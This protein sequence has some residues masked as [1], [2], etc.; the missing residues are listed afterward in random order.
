MTAKT[1]RIIR[2][3]IGDS[4]A[5]AISGWSAEVFAAHRQYGTPALFSRYPRRCC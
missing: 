5:V 3:S 2:S 1:K 4:K